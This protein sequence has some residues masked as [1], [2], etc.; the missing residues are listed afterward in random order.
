[1]A[2]PKPRPSLRLDT[3]ATVF[4]QKLE[5]E[6]GILDLLV[7]ALARGQAQDAHWTRL[8]E[9]AQRDERLAELAFAY[10]RLS[11]DKKL[12]SLTA[13][14]QA[15]VLGHA[16]TF[17]ADVFGDADGAEGYLERALSLAP[18][19]VPAFE[20]YA[21]ILRAKRDLRRLGELYATAA[22]HRGDR[23][24]QLRL[25]REGAE[26]VDGDP[27]RA[28]RLNQEILRLDSSDARARAALEDLY[29]KTGRLADLARLLEQSLGRDPAPAAD[30]ARSIRLRLLSLY[31]GGLGEIERALPHVE[32]VL[33][34]DPLHEA[35]RRVAEELLGHKAL[36]A[37]VAGAL[38]AAYAEA[39]EPAEAARMLGI[40]IETLRGPKRLEAQKRLAALTLEQLGDLEKTFALDEAIVPLDP[41]DHDVRARFVQLASALDKQL[42]ATR[43]LTRAATGS[44]DPAVRARIG[45][46]LGNLYRE[47]GDARKAR[48]AFQ[49]VLDA[50]ADEEATLHAARALAAI[51][52]EPRDPRALAAVL[53]RLAQI[54]PD[55]D[56]R[57]AATAELA[58]LAEEEIGDPA[59]AIAAHEKLV[60]TR[61]EAG[62]LEALSRLYE[63]TG[64]HAALAGVLD[65]RVAGE[66]D[67]GRARELAFRAADL[68][69]SKLP[70]RA[71]ALE[72]W[73]AWIATYGASRE[74]QGRLVPLL[75]HERRWEDLAAALASEAELTPPEERAAVLS[76]LGQLRLARLGDAPGSLEAHR[77]ALALDPTERQSRPAVDRML[78]AGELR[79]AAADVLEPIARAEGSAPALVRV[80]EARAALEVDPR[81]RLAALQEAAELAHRSLRDARRAVDLAGRGLGEALAAA[82]DEVPA[83]IDRI[84]ELSAGAG[85]VTRRA[86][87]LRDALGERPIE[88]PVLALLGRRAGEALVASGDVAGALA[89]FRRALAF[90][91]S[92]PEL[93]ARVDALL[94]EQGSP[95]ERLALYRAALEQAAEP[96]RRRELLHAIGA[97]ERRDLGSPEAAVAT[98][99][100]AL[101]E[102]PSDRVARDALLELYEGEGAWE[103]LYAELEGALGRAAGDERAAIVLRLAEV[104][105]RRG[106]L[107]RAAAHYGEILA[108]EGVPAEEVLAAAERVAR[109]RDDVPL[110][111][112]VFER[113]VAVA[114]DPA[115]EATWLERLGELAADRLADPA[116][117]ADAWRRAAVAAETAGEAPRAA[118]L[119][120]RVLAARPGDRAA[121]T[122]LLDLYREAEAW[123]RLPDVYAV[124]LASAPDAAEAARVLLAFEAPAIRAG[125]AD[126]FLAE[127]FAVLAR[128]AL[129]LE[130][131]VSVRSARARVLAADPARRPEAIAAYRTILKDGDDPTGAEVR[132]FDALLGRIGA[133]A[134]DDRRW[135]FAHRVERA[136]DGDRIPILL[137]WAEAEETALGDPAAAAELYARVS[138][139]DPEHDDALAARARLLLAQGDLEGAAEAIDRR[140]AQR[141]GS[142]RAALDLELATLLLERL[143]RPLEALDAVA[144][145]LEASPADPAALRLV[146]RALHRPAS[147]RRAAELLERAA[148]AAE[149]SA[150]SSALLEV[151]LSTPPADPELGEAR[152]GWFGRLLDRPDLPP[153]Q[154]LAVALRAASELP[155]DLSLWERAEEL[156]RALGSP[157]RLAEAYRRTLGVAAVRSPHS[158]RPI[159]G[160]AVP[161]SSSAPALSGVDAEVIEEVGRRAVEYHEEWF[162]EPDTVIALLRRVVELA[163]GSPWAFERLKLVYNLNERWDDLFALYDDAVARTADVDT[164]RELLEDAALAAKDLA[165]DPARAMGYYQA[166]LEIRPD[167]RT[168]SALERL[169]ERHGRHRSLIELIAAELPSQVGEAAQKLRARIANLWLEGVGEP[170]PAV[171]VIE[172]MLD[173]EPGRQEAFDLLERVMQ[174]TAAGSPGSLGA[175]QRAAARLKD[176]YRAQGRAD[177]LVRVLEIDLDAAATPAERAAR[178]RAIVEL[179]LGKLGD[180]AGA[181]EGVAALV[182]LEPAVAEHRAELGRLAERLGRQARLAE[183]LAT[184]AGAAEG[185]LQIELLEQAEAVY[186]DRLHDKA[187]A[188]KLDWAI[189]VAAGLRDAAMLDA[190]RRLEKLVDG[191]DQVAERCDVLARLGNLE[192]E[193]AARRAVRAELARLA[194]ASGDVERALEAFRAAFDEDPG[195]DAAYEGLTRLLE[196][197]DKPGELVGVLQRRDTREAL[198]RACRVLDDIIGADAEGVRAWRR[199]RERFGADEESTDGLAAA[200][201]GAVSH[202]QPSCLGELV[203][204]LEAEAAAA[205]DPGRAADLWRRLGDV[206]RAHT[207]EPDEAVAA[208][209]LALEQRP[210]HPGSREGLE[211]MVAE[212]DP[213]AP[214]TRRTLIAVL[215]SLSRI[216]AAEDAFARTIALLEPRLAV[217]A[218]DA[219]RVAVLSETAGLLERRAGDPAGA[220]DALFR[221]FAIAPGDALAADLTRLA[222]AADRWRT[223]AEALGRDLGARADVPVAVA[224]E[225]WWRVALWQRDGRGDPAA[226]EAAL[227]QALARD[228]ESVPILEALAG[229]Q[230]RAPGRS[231]ITTLLRLA[232][233]TD[234]DLDRYREAV[235]IAEGPAGDPALAKMLAEKL[236]DAATARWS[237]GAP[238]ILAAS[239]ALDTMV[240]LVHDEGP[241]AMADL[242]LRGARLPFDAGERRRLRVRAAEL[243]GADATV[244]IYQELFDEDPGDPV[245]GERLDAIY[246]ELGRCPALIALRERQIAVAATVERRAELRFDLASLLA[247]GGE[248]ERAIAALRENLSAAP[249]HAPSVARLAELLEAGSHHAELCAL[250]EDRAAEAETAGDRAGA[251]ALWI[252]AAALAEAELADPARAVAAHRRA[253]ALGAEESEEALARL[254][255]ARGDHAGAAAVLERICE[256]AGA[257]AL[258]PLL[259]LVD[260]YLAAAEPA[261]ARA[262]LER[263]AKIGKPSAALRDRLSALYREAGEWGLLAT[264]IAEDAAKTTDRAARAALLREAAELHLERHDD[265]AAAIP[266]LE[267]AVEILP[268]DVVVRLKLASARRGVG[269]LD[270]AAATLRAMITGYGGRRPKERALVHFELARVG[271]AKGERARALGELD[272]A[273]RIDP[274]QPD[275]LLAL[276]RLAFEEGQLERAGRTYRSLL[277][278]V[279][280]PK[281]DEPASMTGP[282]RA[283]VLFELSEIARRT[284]DSERAAEQLESAFEA[285]RESDGERDRL[286]AAIRARGRHDVLARALEARLAA[287]APG[288]QAAIL[289]ELASLYEEH[290]GRPADALEARLSA[291]ALGSPGAAA[292]ERA[293]ELARRAGQV[294][295]F[296][297]AL[298]KLALGGATDGDVDRAIDQQILLGRALERDLGDDRRA[299]EAYLRAEALAAGRA[300][301]LAGIWRSLVGVY[302]RLGDVAAQE[303][304][305]ERRIDAAGTE[306][307]ERADAL[308]R[309]AA[310]RLQ[311]PAAEVDGIAL[312]ER[313]FE[314]APDADRAE[315]ILREALARGADGALVAHSLEQLARATGRDRTLIDALVLRSRLDG[316]SAPTSVG[317]RFADLREAVAI[318]ER[319]DD[320]A[321]VEELLRRAL[322]RAPIEGDAELGW[323][324]SALAARRIE[325]GDLAEAAD[326][327]ERA[328]RAAP[329]RERAILLEVA[330]MSGGPLGDLP[331]AARLYEELRAREPAEREIWQP[332]ADVYRRLGDLARLGA[333]LEETAP[334]LEGA[335]ERGKLRLERAK[336]AMGEDQE[337]AIALLTEVLEEIPAEVEA[338][339]VLGALLEK[340]GRKEELAALYQKQIEAAKD[341]EDR[342]AIRSL[343][344]RLG[345]LLEAQWDEQGALD[346]YHAALDWEP[347]SAEIL[348]QIVRLGMSRDDSLALGDS[349]DQLLAVERG[350]DA[351]DL[352]LRLSQIRG[353][354]GD[355][356][357]AER[358]LEQ[359]FETSPENARLRDELTRRYTESGAWHKLADLH[360]RDAEAREDK[361]ERV[362]G[363]RRAA[364][365]LGDQA[366]DPAAAAAILER[367]LAVDPSDRDVLVALMTACDAVGEH[368]RAIEAIG[369]ALAVHPKDPWLY[370][371]RASL[372]DALGRDRETLLDLESAYEKS[373]GGYAVELVTALTGAAAA[374]AERATPEARAMERGLRL[375]LAEVLGRTGDHE[376]ARAELTELTRTDARDRDAL[377]ALAALEE[378]AGNWDAAISIHRRLLALE[379]GEGLVETA[380]RMAAACGKADRL[381]DARGALER[382]LRVAPDHAKVRARL[383]D[384][385]NITGAG[386][387]LALMIL[388]DAAHA[389][390][391]AGRFALLTHAGRLLL[392]AEGEADRAA[393]VLEEAKSLRPEDPDTTLLLADAYTIAG[394]L[395]ES[396]GVLEAAVAAHKGRRSKALAAVLRRIARLDVAEGD[397]ASALGALARAFDNEPQSAPL[398][399]ELGALAVELEDHELATRAFRGVTLMKITTGTPDGATTALRAVAYYHLGRMAFI[400]GD[401][402]KARLMI[403]K[404]IVDDPGLDAARALLEQL[405]SS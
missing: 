402:R 100:R 231:L 157:E 68:R 2:D 256:R 329:D 57:L 1:M 121:A 393:A 336:M 215:A 149:D 89:V 123:D 179:R 102:D 314:V 183:V 392:D 66:R 219:E 242:Y 162:D 205:R 340:L 291:L 178:L 262:K 54:E 378:L 181:F 249:P 400:Q 204:L 39:G 277:L 397:R 3:L 125:A 53:G 323:A 192:P 351:A 118:R 260:A 140:R 381:G 395:R 49:T 42:E 43:T 23:G 279:R 268:E 106:W 297:A 18:G 237:R 296:V 76:R 122:R 124:L 274:A 173:H 223:I 142:A 145:V 103:D 190:V 117:A 326:L 78:S 114:I 281:G 248:P 234:G 218:T 278:V 27:E 59:A 226:A 364:E 11:R 399:M 203:E 375:R 300:D 120:E 130:A 180:E 389:P 73:Q 245:V 79:L 236:L 382:A 88:S 346:V 322:A 214:E 200:L 193:P 139:I 135:L 373:G 45:A 64:A 298:S 7:S 224:R 253:A 285:A 112:A 85:D 90:E 97:I 345:A 202:G 52:A 24:E 108:G 44:K 266:L 292:I 113:R 309:L 333:L 199:L 156:A 25:L 372:Q 158:T 132:A 163:P 195:D 327:K 194:T 83:W 196:E 17:F 34:V 93:L 295:R 111:R 48:A 77:Q 310:L 342:P 320:R 22:A 134:A 328:A 263:A 13:A 69:S 244:G 404:A 301:R 341:R 72:A 151:L 255:S 311:R 252:K 365:L 282:T 38:G 366:G 12:K 216:D 315:A 221:A 235:E 56:A 289:D 363:L 96:A 284:G 362:A 287:G 131:R 299:A 316:D 357:G 361:R 61:L 222:D 302:E 141:E 175:R 119:H 286:L 258:P 58:R 167:P 40:E 129:A 264:L 185:P 405:K 348:R 212:L 32:E 26:L 136:A 232:E 91:P 50:G 385:Y 306:P 384:V 186:R 35:A 30:E 168:R 207:R 388:E 80:L 337:K 370:R 152:R 110:L 21:Q 87:A 270:E 84:E 338:A 33:R 239:W 353:N 8:H 330:A 383:R 166:L 127:A 9:A 324:L 247:E 354:H 101:K 174:R 62:A 160:S 344:L 331:R 201:E 343:S 128:D 208:Y 259:R 319:L 280:R 146:E 150:A 153:D 394:R 191:E 347:K 220:F 228:P 269:Q 75:E 275:I 273:L 116:A 170:E 29:E 46:D 349:L 304:L 398:A 99:K 177:D 376:R 251:A 28:V 267:Q 71:A 155:H 230:R 5:N 211:A 16:G 67:P 161:E 401:R 210:G 137:A 358:A 81:R 154:A 380:L 318:A 374:C 176:H 288:A 182:T 105:A 184:A 403:D 86:A 254:L 250:T 257:D 290:L 37:R 240:R 217:A 138:A 377:R 368:E 6:A 391:V 92:S 265:A 104:A 307:A 334:L 126:R 20:K 107:D 115:D 82:L 198:L 359:A 294:P 272:A 144:P 164:R 213:R 189:V 159:P 225:L 276:A 31:A 387:E 293:L 367:A 197:G 4:E 355:P 98:Y 371:A 148:D 65:R 352:A 305:L 261:K 313:A 94:R 271:L 109:A 63:V 206:H 386:R 187:Q 350:E 356:E 229:V 308:Y 227:E 70:D 51:S 143:D 379:D 165:S 19:D 169:Y 241:A 369:R 133:E 15:A 325:A 390:D 321:L 147:R 332:L 10:E 209:D 60:G 55:E 246:R 312:L 47:L 317:D 335:A 41:A 360:V 95:E 172:R 233:A 243:S 36:T 238:A 171:I 339:E 396:R 14:A 283:E 188:V 74:A 303:A